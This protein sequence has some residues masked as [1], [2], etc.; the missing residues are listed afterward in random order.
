M[1]TK[2][3]GKIVLYEPLDQNKITD[4]LAGP[5][6]IVFEVQRQYQ[7]GEV[8]ELLG[9]IVPA[10]FDEAVLKNVIDIA[11]W[12]HS[13]DALIWKINYDELTKT[14]D[15]SGSYVRDSATTSG[16]LT[17]ITAGQYINAVFV[18]PGLEGS[19]QTVIELPYGQ[20]IDSADVTILN[21]LGIEIDDIASTGNNLIINVQKVPYR[22]FFTKPN[23]YNLL[24]YVVDF[25]Y[26]NKNIEI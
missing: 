14:F 22:V 18:T 8:P 7:L 19:I 20:S 24:N 25:N 11:T 13:E 17:A 23:K 6:T 16:T 1:A 5:D 2:V 21:N 12:I 4:L 10:Q 26:K 15:L 3:I 9:A